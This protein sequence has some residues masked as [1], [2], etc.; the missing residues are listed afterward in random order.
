V[1]EEPEKSQ[2]RARRA[3][4]AREELEKSQRRVEEEWEKSQRRVGKEVYG[5]RA[6]GE[7][8]G[9]FTPGFLFKRKEHHTH[10]PL[11]HHDA[12]YMPRIDESTQMSI[13]S[14]LS[15]VPS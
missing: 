11:H 13:E 2:R 4:R 5:R 8:Y 15:S 12:I 9:I 14:S 1:R 10:W 7:G 3:R 6:R